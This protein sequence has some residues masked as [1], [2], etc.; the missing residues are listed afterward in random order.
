MLVLS[1]ELMTLNF[2]WL[3]PPVRRSA[4]REGHESND[5][6]GSRPSRREGELLLPKGR[7]PNDSDQIH[8][9][10]QLGHLVDL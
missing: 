6:G 1:T 2:H 7:I 10:N 5:T 3:R 9:S 4:G 8:Q